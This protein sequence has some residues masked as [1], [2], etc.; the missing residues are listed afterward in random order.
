MTSCKND[1]P[2]EE[3][4]NVCSKQKPGVSGVIID[5][6]HVRFAGPVL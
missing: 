4:A 5:Y 1:D 2:H 6:E 3:V